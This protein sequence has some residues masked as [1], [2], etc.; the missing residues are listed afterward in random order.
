M[1]GKFDD[2]GR[3][4][5]LA[6]RAAVGSA[7]LRD[8]NDPVWGSVAER[9]TPVTEEIAKGV[10]GVVVCRNGARESYSARQISPRVISH[11]ERLLDLRLRR[12]SR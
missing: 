3:L 9:P 12:A 6:Q 8:Q 7:R 2:V 5:A 11:A 1:R 4:A 10:P